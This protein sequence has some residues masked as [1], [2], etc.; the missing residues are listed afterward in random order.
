MGAKTPAK[1]KLRRPMYKCNICDRKLLSA[2][3]LKTHQYCIHNLSK[4]KPEANT[5][6]AKDM[7][8]VQNKTTEPKITS[9]PTVEVA[10]QKKSPV[11]S[12]AK[13]S[14]VRRIEFQCP[15][16]EKLFD[17]YFSAYRHIQK[18]HCVNSKGRKVPSSSPDLIKPI[19]VELCVKCNK[20][21]HVNDIH[22]CS[23]TIEHESGFIT[24]Y[25]CT[26][27]SQGFSTI[28]VFDLHISGLHSDGVDSMFFPTMNEFLT[29]K[30]DMES[31]TKIKY[32]VLGKC[33]MKQTY[34][35]TFLPS[36]EPADSRTA[37]FC[38][39]SLVVQE[40]TKGI[41]VHY[42]KQ[43]Y[44]HNCEKYT[45][46]DTYKKYHI[47]PIIAQASS[48]ECT[49]VVTED[50]KDLYVQFKTLMESI[51]LEAAKVKIDT[52][53]IMVGK[54]LEM[55]SVLTNYEEDEEMTSLIEPQV[56]TSKSMTD[57]QITKAL[58]SLQ[59]SNKRKLEK[60][61][62][63]DVDVNRKLKKRNTD[64]TVLSPKIINAF[65]M[66]KTVENSKKQTEKAATPASTKPIIDEEAARIKYK[67]LM[68]S[69]SYN[70]S[71]KDFLDKNFKTGIEH[72]NTKTET[73]KVASLNA[74][75][76][77]D[78][79]VNVANKKNDTPSKTATKTDTSSKNYLLVDGLK[80]ISTSNMTTVK[81]LALTNSIAGENKKD[82]P[83]SKIDNKKNNTDLLVESSKQT[84]NKNISKTILNK[85]DITS[86]KTIDAKKDSPISKLESKKDSTS[87][88]AEIKRT[89]KKN[90]VKTKIGQFKP[91]LSPKKSTESNTS[92]TSINKSI[93]DF[94]Y[95]VKEQEN[96]CNIL[97]LKI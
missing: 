28:Q 8:T 82:G 72:S 89:S 34:R 36:G 95:E 46:T 38:P 76:K 85:K 77:K 41:Q 92:N 97:I 59:N 1:L 73:R 67:S 96:D 10:E 58:Q 22:V 23:D 24:N 27:C 68:Q 32:L 30:N 7:K 19:R 88:S 57:D 20:K 9:K 12:P 5:V 11:I 51:V 16:C 93:V 17:V 33:N 70:D 44:G 74:E 52:L 3:A 15:K 86:S 60:D 6:R 69:P 47:T 79:N 49:E 81:K 62:D 54:A 43:H 45:L 50:E 61:D 39:S 40:F 18:H 80:G 94:E 84:T 65:S 87:K 13:L 55:T 37:H 56:T 78:A 90:I 14:D 71:Y 31:Q 75:A 21:V 63:E 53:K 35:C 2:Q 4:P 29:W 66:A 25:V 91:S 83:I 64:I 42:Y 26:G 48:Y